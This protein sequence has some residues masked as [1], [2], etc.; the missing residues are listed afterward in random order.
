LGCSPEARNLTITLGMRNS[1]LAAGCQLVRH[2][3]ALIPV[4]A[5]STAHTSFHS[6]ARRLALQVRPLLLAVGE[7]T[8]EEFADLYAQLEKELQDTLF[9]GTCLIHTFWGKK[10][11]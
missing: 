5:H 8:G 10:E 11:A 7:L 2:V 3:P 1:L 9:H 6:Q 4:S